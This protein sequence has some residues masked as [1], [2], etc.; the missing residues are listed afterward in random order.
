LNHGRNLIIPKLYDRLT[1]PPRLTKLF[2]LSPCPRCSTRLLHEPHGTCPRPKHD[3]KNVSLKFYFTFTFLA[4]VYL[5]SVISDVCIIDEWTTELKLIKW[6][7]FSGKIWNPQLFLA[8]KL[9]GPGLH[10]VSPFCF[11]S[12]FGMPLMVC[13]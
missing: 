2:K 5:R 3:L 6:K 7:D 4:G 12:I 10:M 1:C 13:R 8:R 9:K 11:T